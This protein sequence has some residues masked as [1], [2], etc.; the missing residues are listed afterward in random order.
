MKKNIKKLFA[1][2]IMGTMVFSLA[3][4]GGKKDAKDEGKTEESNKLIVGTEAGFAPY[5][6][7]DGDQVV[8]IDM[9]IAKA[10][11][12]AMG[13]ELEIKNMDFDGALIAV[14]NGKVDLV[15]AG[16]SI[17][18]ERAKVMDFSKEYVNSTEVVVVNKENPTVSSIEDLNDKIIGVQQGNI[19]DFW[20][21]NEENVK[22]A[23]IK[24]YTKFA[25]AA[26]D[27]KNGKVDCIVMDQYP[28]EELVAANDTL[29][30]LDGTLFEDKYAIAVKKGNQEL[31]DQIN[32]TITTLIEEGKIEEFTAN[33][34]GK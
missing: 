27:L 22:P 20:V 24:R 3:A 32:D 10:I 21:S 14:Q 19:A 23:D 6:Y 33:H 30:V 17:D 7:M 9:D 2:V 26:E 31:L 5:E 13:K 4:C 1:M 8:G 16:V 34:T 25:Q 12:D 11:A 18:P 15:A 28:A 29:T